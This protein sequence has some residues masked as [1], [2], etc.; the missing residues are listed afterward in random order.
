MSS[1]NIYAMK[2]YDFFKKRNNKDQ[3]SMTGSKS[4]DEAI[5]GLGAGAITTL[6]LHPIDN[7]KTRLQVPDGNMLSM[8]NLGTFKTFK[9]IINRD[10]YKGL[11]QGLTPNLAGG[12]ISWG[13]Y[14]WWYS[15][16][17]DQLRKKNNGKRL[18]KTQNLIASSQS[19]LL[20]QICTNPIWLIKTRMC[21]Q[22]PDDPNRYRNICD[23]VK[24]I[25]KA[26]GFRGFYKGMIPTLF[27]TSH[28]A[29]QFVT[30]EEMKNIYNDKYPYKEQIDTFSY[31]LMAAS[32]KIFASCVTYPYQVV[33]AR[34]QNQRNFEYYNGVVDVIK[35]IYA[36]EG[37]RGYYKGMVP[38][39]I[40]VLPSTCLT[41]VVYE[42]LSRFFRTAG[43]SESDNNNSHKNNT[44]NTN[45]VNSTEDIEMYY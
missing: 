1:S 42:S 38:N 31:I 33:R 15:I 18:T 34:L 20:A 44:N 40:R 41:F 29:I 5:A 43:K 4:I 2:I 14:F 28:G 11:Y 21:I 3:N 24:H 22:R 23:A 36:R 27:G 10:G 35:K 26:E 16:K 7:I 6:T 8:K 39:V 30:Y 45:N 32:S 17:K 25:Y 9:Y 19:G 12:A 13:I 37:L